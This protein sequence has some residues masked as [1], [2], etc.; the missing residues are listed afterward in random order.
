[1]SWDPAS[2]FLL[3]F[4]VSLGLTLI[5]FAMG[6]A[7][8]SIPHLG[9]D[10]GSAPADAGLYHPSIDL[11]HG[12]G[13]P[14]LAHAPDLFHA[15]DTHGGA[16]TGG[17]PGLSPFN[18]ATILAF[19]TWFGGAGFILTAYFSFV[20]VVALAAAVLVGLVGA[21]GV[22]LFLS[23]VLVP[24]QTPALRPEDYDLDGTVGELT[25]GIRAGGT[26]EMV[27]TQAGRRFVAAAR[28]D[29]ASAIDRGAE[30]VVV[31]H[32]DGI[33]YVQTL[34]Q[35]LGEERPDAP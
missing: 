11:G 23:R 5:S 29:D 19:L 2:V 20:A 26:G 21:A 4:L 14:P 9:H 10:F 25:V 34:D 32:E 17:D 22:F 28:S 13:H 16:H 27:Y 12:A 33:L 31:R 1:M 7:H 15:G 18:L 24:G 35:L 30:V 3:I 6:V 8:L